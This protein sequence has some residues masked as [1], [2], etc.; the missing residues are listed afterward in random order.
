[1]PLDSNTIQ[2][3]AQSCSTLCNPMDCS[4]L[5]SSVEKATAT[6]SST[7]AWKIPWAEEPGRLQSMGSQRVRHDWATSLSLF[8]FMHWTRKWQLI[9]IGKIVAVQ[10]LSHVWLFAIPWTAACQASLSFTISWS[11][12]KLMSIESVMPSNHLILCCPFLLLPSVFP[13][14]RV[15]S[16]ES[17]IHIRWPKYWSFSFNISSSNEHPGLISFRMDWLDL[18]AVQGTLKSLLQHHS[19]KA[20][21]LQC[22]AFFMFQLSHQYK[23]TAE[24]TALTTRSF[25][26]LCLA[27]SWFFSQGTSI[28][29][30]Y[31][32]SHQGTLSRFFSIRQAARETHQ[33]QGDQTN[34]S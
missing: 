17:A 21:V 3:E 18:L 34:Q 13:S 30:F 24:N 14:I 25:L 11:L 16:S 28:F 27:L 22:S 12:L 26:I 6:H 5:G 10:S 32:C 31:A 2:L 29:S 20:S 1:M 9:G 8:I 4:P 19:S 7:L 23:T 15:F 33:Q